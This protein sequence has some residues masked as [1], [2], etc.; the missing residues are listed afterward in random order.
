MARRGTAPVR[1]EAIALTHYSA[2]GKKHWVVEKPHN[3]YTGDFT[4]Q[5]GSFNQPGNAYSLQKK[6]IRTYPNVEVIPYQL[7]EKVYYRV[8]LLHFSNL[9]D[10]Q[11][12][13]RQFW[14]RG[15]LDAF[16]VAE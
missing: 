15:F 13:M 12:V 2:A 6:L 4:I 1:I 11:R 3:L 9:F 10:A 16:V 7:G 5:V 14:N 8:R